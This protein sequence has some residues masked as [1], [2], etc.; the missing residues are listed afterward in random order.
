V[1]AAG[2]LFLRSARESVR[3]ALVFSMRGAATVGLAWMFGVVFG[4]KNSAVDCIGS[5]MMTSINS[6]MIALVRALLT[7]V[8]ERPVVARELRFYGVAPYLL[9]KARNLTRMNRTRI[10]PPRC[11]HPRAPLSAAPTDL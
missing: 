2:A 1:Q 3:D 9:S 4:A 7:F 10:A 8:E 6:C 11:E 5:V